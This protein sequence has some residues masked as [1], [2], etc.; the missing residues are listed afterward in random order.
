MKSMSC[1]KRS[2]PRPSVS[3]SRTTQLNLKL[4]AETLM[5]QVHVYNRTL[6]CW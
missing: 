6:V 4:Q 2:Q 3:V 1:N 5:Q